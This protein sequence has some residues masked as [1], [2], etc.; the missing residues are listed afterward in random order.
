[1]GAVEQSSANVESQLAALDEQYGSFSVNQTTVAVSSDRYERERAAV[2]KG[3]L[4]VYTK[5]HHDGSI[6]HIDDDAGTD[7]P[8]TTATSVSQVETTAIETVAELTGIECSVD[9]V[10]QA[11]ILGFRDADDDDRGTIYKLAV[12]IE[13]TYEAGPVSGDAEWRPVTDQQLSY[14]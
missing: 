5:V 3:S 1:M 4:D 11:T 7:L 12:V 6:L 2:G 14:A 9:G 8:S 13:A 10:D